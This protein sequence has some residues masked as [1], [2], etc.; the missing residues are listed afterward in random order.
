MKVTISRLKQLIKEELKEVLSE[1]NQQL[2]FQKSSEWQETLACLGEGLESKGF[3]LESKGGNVRGGMYI[4]KKDFDD[5][6]KMRL[7]IQEDLR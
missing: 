7:K 1:A 5:G 2:Q 3:S 4:Y 6:S